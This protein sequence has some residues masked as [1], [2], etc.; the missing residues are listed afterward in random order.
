SQRDHTLSVVPSLVYGDPPEARIEGGA[1]VH[2][3][4]RVP[5]RDEAT[6]RELVARLRDD[7]NLA[8]DRR[9][10]FDG[11]AAIRFA[12]K[13]AAF[14]AREGEPHDP[15]GKAS[16]VPRVHIDDRAFEVTFG[17][18]AED[19]DEPTAPRRADA[20]AVLKAYQDNLPWVPLLGGGF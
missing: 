19:G 9:V 8:P 5:A 3:G 13:L 6:E 16:L 20:A 1:L 10:D 15:F 12:Q 7:L 17:L 2:L 4:G 14:S 11:D 18:A